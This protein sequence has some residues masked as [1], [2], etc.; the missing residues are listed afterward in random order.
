MASRTR[1]T[2][3]CANVAAIKAIPPVKRAPDMLAVDSATG[4][5]WRFDSDS[6]ASAGDNALVP[7]AGNGRWVPGDLRALNAPSMQAVAATLASGTATINTGIVVA[8]N[9]EVVP[10]L[11]GAITGSTNFASLRE[12]KSSRVNG[13]AGTG[14]ITID[15]VGA[16]GAKDADAAGAIRVL[17]FAPQS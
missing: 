4:Y 10:I 9:S 11:I 5:L 6:S 14:S 7:D 1:I 17:I 8:S 13:A 15:A 3:S 2:F 12:L 16:D